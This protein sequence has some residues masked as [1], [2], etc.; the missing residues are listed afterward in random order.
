LKRRV[1]PVDGIFAVRVAGIGDGLLDGVASVGSRPMM[2]GGKT[3][4]EVFLFDFDRDI[5]GKYITVSFIRRLREERTFVDLAAMQA[6]MH[7]DVRDARAALA[8]GIA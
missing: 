3:L 2:G 5:Y 7:A 1:A 6:Q 8:G 4:L